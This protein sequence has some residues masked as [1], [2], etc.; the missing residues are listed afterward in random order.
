MDKDQE[1]EQLKR[2][3]KSKFATIQKLRNQIHSKNVKEARKKTFN[4]TKQIIQS[5]KPDIPL[6]I[7]EETEAK[8]Q[9]LKLKK[10]FIECFLENL[11]KGANGKK[12]S[13]EILD[14]CFA[15][16]SIS[17]NS[18]S[19]LRNILDLPCESTLKNHFKD[20]VNYEKNNLIDINKAV[21]IINDYRKMNGIEDN[22][23]VVLGVDACSFDRLNS[24][25]KKYSFCFYCQPIHPDLK[26]FP[27][28]LV[29][30]K[31]G[32]ASTVII[33]IMNKLKY[34]LDSCGVNVI[35]TCSDGDG[36]YNELNENT[37]EIYKE[38]ALNKGFDEAFDA[39]IQSCAEKHI[40]DML[41]CLK[42]AR[43]RLLAGDITLNTDRI[44][45]IINA[46]ILESIL[47]LG[48]NLKDKLYRQNEG[49]LCY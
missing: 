35:Y 43:K 18:Y 12:Y 26:C 19:V 37:F 23:D 40:S 46:D 5:L 27:L 4:E 42:I 14:I 29:P 21:N 36:G 34:I 44:D 3:L 10:I 11:N 39:W 25:G 32:K 6:L 7:D 1:K 8:N 30:S 22:F 15:L 16:H 9:N 24:D 47:L 2:L 31:N 41:H 49:F 17:S 20:R 48:P 33:D 13:D 45:H 38:I 28:H